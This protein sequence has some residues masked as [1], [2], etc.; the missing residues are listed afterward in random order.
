[1]TVLLS[2]RTSACL[3]RAVSRPPIDPDRNPNPPDSAHQGVSAVSAYFPAGTWYDA[4]DEGGDAPAVVAGP[5]GRS[6]RLDAPLGAV[7]VHY[8]GGVVLPLHAGGL[9]TAA[10]RASALTLVAALPEPARTGCASRSEF[11]AQVYL[12][13]IIGCPHLHLCPQEPAAMPTGLACMPRRAAPRPSARQSAGRRW[14]CWAARG[15]AG[16]RRPAAAPSLTTATTWRRAPTAHLSLIW[17]WLSVA[18]LVMLLQRRQHGGGR[19]SPVA[20]ARA[21][22]SSRDSAR[23]AAEA[24]LG[25]GF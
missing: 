15:P 9:T 24:F 4:W 20:A 25:W 21:P 19:R 16:R 3:L 17:L 14:R 18:N 12:T 7:P 13:H 8:R 23:A 2:R 22:L 5:D 6:E 10:A 11:F 1:M